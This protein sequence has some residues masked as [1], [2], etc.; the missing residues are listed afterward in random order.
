MGFLIPLCIPLLLL[1][2]DVGSDTFTEIPQ[3]T[4]TELLT[5]TTEAIS[6]P[7]TDPCYNYSILDEPWRATNSPNYWWGL[8][9]DQYI[10][11]NGWYRLLHQ[12][13]SVRMPDSCVSEN[14]CGT[15]APLWLNGPHPRLEDGVVSRQVCGSWNG[16]C[17]YFNSFPIQVKA[18]P[19]NYYVYEFVSPNGCSLAYCADV[20]N[21][22]TTEI[23]QTTTTETLPTTTE[24]ISNPSTD[25]CDNYSILDEPW[26]ATN[27]PNYWWGV[28]CDQYTSWNGWYRLLHQGNSVRMPDS[29]VSENMCG[30]H[31]PLW[32]NGPHPRL[33]DGV[34]SRQVCGSW[35]GACCFFNSSPI[36]V[37]ACPGDYYVYEFVRPSSCSLAYCADV[38]NE[39]TTEIPQTTTTETLPTTTEAISN[40]STDPCDNYSI[41]DEPWRATNS[42]NYWWGVHCD[43]YTSWN[44]WYRLLHQGNSVRMP[45]SCVSENMC[46]THAP[47]WLNGPHPRL[48]DGVVSRQVCGS[49]NG[50]CCFFNSSPI[51]VK[52]CP[53]DYYVYEFVRPSSCS[54]AYCAD[55]GNETTTEI[56]QTT[57]TET[58]PT[59][60]EAI[61]NPSTDPCDNYSILDEPWRATNSPNYWWGVHCDQYTSWNGWYRL[62]H[63]GNSVRMPDS[64]VSENMCGT[65]APLWL[66]GPHPRLEDGVVS[67]QVCGSWNGACCFFNSSPIQVK[68]CPGDYYV[69]EFVRPSSCSLAYCADVGNET[70]TEIPQTTTTETLP[71]TTDVGSI[72]P[73]EITTTTQPPTTTTETPTTTAPLNTSTG[74]FYPFGVG[75]IEN[76]RIDDGGSPAI[77]LLQHFIFFGTTYAQ[78]YVNNNGHLTF[79]Q[80]WYSYVP[81]QFP[82]NAGRDIIAPYWTDIDNYYNGIIS[83]QQYTSGSVLTQATQDINQ[84]FPQL[85]FNATWVFVA[86]WNRVG[87]CCSNSGEETSF[88]V[89]L[90]SD[91]RLSFVLMNY[92]HIAPTSRA[93]QAGY[94]TS[95][96]SYYFSIPGS[97]QRNYNNDFTYTSNVNVTGRWAFRVDHGSQTCQF[98]GNTVPQG[99]SFWTDS[100]CWE[101]CTCTRRGLQC[102]SQ[103]CTYSQACRPAALEYS[104][105]NVQRQTCT[106]SGD[107][108][109]YTFDN[110]IFHFQGTCTYVLSEACGD[111]LPY[112]RI[113]GKNE[114]RGSTRV[115]W[116]RLVRVFVYDEELELVKDHQYEAKVNGSFASTPFSLRNGSIQVYQSG[117][118]VAISTDFGLVVTYDAYSYVTISVPFD[119]QN[120][121]CGL[122]GNFNH[123]PE[124]DFRT[125]SGEV[126]S[127]DTDFANSWT[128]TGDTDPGCQNTCSGLTCAACTEAQ[129]SLYSNSDY[130][131]ILGD[132]AGPFSSCHSRLS[133]QTFMENCIY[134]LCV[135]GGYQPILCQALNVY[136]AQC[137]QQGVQL[138][139]WR[140]QGFCEISC[141]RNSH[142]ESSG[143]S[144]PATCS[145]PTAPVNCPLPNQESCICD[146][147]YV[148][149]AGECVSQANCGCTFEGLYYASGQSVI[150]DGDCGRQCSCNSGVMSCQN[151][152]CGPQEMCAIHNG[153]RGCRPIG[154]STCWVEGPGFYHTY[155]GLMF[156]YPGACEL[157]LSRVM[158]LSPLPNFAVTIQK[159][160]SGPQ[161]FSRVLTF[162]AEGTQVSMKMEEGGTATVDGQEVA[163]PFS[164]GSGR[165]HI[166]HSSVKG[167]IMET[168]FGV[169]VRADWPHLIRIT[170]P[171]TYNGTLGGLC[172]N[173]NEYLE[174]E[175]LSPDGVLLNDSRTF[176][177]SWR[178]GSLS[179]HCEESTDIWQ[180]GYYQDSNQFRMH[181]SILS[182]PSGPFAQCH[183]SLDPSA[184]VEDCISSLQ[185]T[186]GAKEA[187]CEALRGYAVLCQQNGIVLQE[188]RNITDCE[189][190][191]PTNSHYELCGTSCPAACPSLSFPYLCTQHCQEGCQCDDGLLLSGDHCVPPIGCGCLQEGRYRQ[192]GERFWYGEQCQSLCICDGTTGFVRCNPSSCSEQETCRIVGGE[193]GCHPQPR[194][195]CSASGDPH[196]TSFDGRNFDFQ[197][198]CRYILSTVC[199]DNQ[200]LPFFQVVAKNEA[201]NG[202]PVSIT[203]EVSVNVSGH[204]VLVS[205]NKRGIA[206]ID[207]ETKN[208]PVLLDSGS[209]SVYSSGQNTFITTDFGLSVSYD[210]S[211]VVR[212]TVPANYSGATCGL[213]GNFNG[214][215]NDDFRIR[216]GELVSSAS[217]FGADWKVGNDTSCDDE[218]GDSCARCQNPVSARSQCEILRDRQGPVSF[219]HSYVDPEA[220]FNDCAFDLCLSEYQ[221]DVLCRSI[222]TYVSAC[223]SANAP[224]LPW[225][226]NTTCRMDCPMNSHYELCG[227]D[228]EH[229]CASSIDSVCE[230]ACSEG[231][232]C[233]EGFVRSGGFCIPVEQCGC[234]Y[235]GFYFNIGEKF[236]NQECSQHCECFAPNDLRCSSISCSPTQEC[237]VKNGQRGCYS[238]MSSCMVWGDP[239]YLTFDGAVTT[240]QGTCSYEISKTCGNLLDNGLEFLVV[241]TNMHRENK[242][243]SFASVVDIWLS[244]GGQRSQITIGQNK[245]VKVDGTDIDSSAFQIGQLA[246]LHQENDFVVVNASSE[247]MV[248]F[249]GRFTLLVRLDESFH[250]SVCGMCGNN[251]GDAADDK[252]MPSGALA[253]SDDEFGNSWRSEISTQGC[254]A[255]DQR[256][257]V[258]D[259]PFTQEYSEVCSIITNTSGPFQHCHFHVN[260]MVYFRSCVYDLCVYSSANGM[261]CSALEAYEVACT[262]MGLEISEWRSDLGCS[263]TDPCAELE[264]TADEWCGEKDNIYGCFC[265]ENHPRPKKESY[266][267]KEECESSSGTMSLSRCQLF[268]AGFSADILHLSDPNCTGTIQNGRL[269]F[270]FDNDAN[271]CGTNLVANGTHFIYENTIQGGADSARGSIHRKKYLELQ[272]SCIYQISQTLSMDTELTPLQSV[273]RKRLPGQGMYQVRIVPYQDAA[274]SQ[275]YNGSV[276]I[277]VDERIY[278]GVFVQGVDSRQIATV[279]D[280]CWA[281]PENDQNHAV[282][283]DLITNRCPNPEDT[284]V[285][286][287]Q[288]GVSTTGRFSFRMFAFNGDYQKVFL[289]C[290][291]HLCILEGNNCAARCFPGFHHRVG[292]SV[293]IHDMASI[294]VGPFIWTV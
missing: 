214:Q 38:G 111:G 123:H 99:T 151:Y 87:Y 56:P 39:T 245:R 117:F 291:I 52:A 6:N 293:D 262:T 26:R 138:G 220:Y 90:I 21:E 290:S 132:P 247:L 231:C 63:Q 254:G 256:Y 286:V 198:T 188:W 270:S 218:C 37:K 194:A 28:H 240:F 136:S 105:Q 174:D 62:L 271:I 224:V 285:E 25:P 202:L 121:T 122:C 108:H 234:L 229:T 162:E 163:L 222:Q 191:C 144:C 167:I 193:Y 242:D 13:N 83:Y 104:C 276:K 199:S 251:N 166:Y 19:G 47:L 211:W 114:H 186:E 137:Q 277:V 221:H 189:F 227:T 201:W 101:R 142:F 103:P 230:H 288:N 74:P 1:I 81:Y 29:C 68:A 134:D 223:Q 236:W 55:V 53:G 127:S 34:V 31:A 51:Q 67:R 58:L 173:F 147:G 116:T 267:S 16:A 113:E 77:S 7:S 213:C 109:Y 294:S 284:T 119:Y 196:Y 8:H 158:G 259:C 102:S 184:K 192:G 264:C 249:D 124:D 161:G 112:Y 23:P 237:M 10:S 239:H 200:D 215:T 140:R 275:P 243:V 96:S 171:S 195:T 263:Y 14:M 131:G 93:V 32:L 272:F 48:E 78:L 279:I 75:D 98:N 246:E 110:Q 22:T 183:S 179:A 43:Q 69:Y 15:H 60:T 278:V 175:F 190:P 107:P 160:P 133:P 155:D 209:V 204:L 157:T 255:I 125:P 120:A 178:D 287:L 130:C 126:L 5:T 217:Q 97:F 225:R 76:G 106:I 143:T 185:Q 232:F 71:T 197:G 226:Q 11:W 238:T 92:G 212:V 283:W 36:Q 89:V 156:S 182:S 154:Y 65:H 84:Y 177:D 146:A 115:S 135:G 85:H 86:T 145:N 257:D 210:G 27:S 54:L 150:L 172:G 45:D 169:T 280:S 244:K 208:L 216:S 180:K 50:A 82:A 46:G 128:A 206:V 18:C 88:Q 80:S 268:E 260:P 129:R 17:C 57:T 79:D 281:T 248:Y 241:A 289:H 253:P 219:C 148:L 168:T 33:E 42:P 40:P 292:R 49:W 152:Q 66:N 24:A 187:L 20:G 61:S 73:S 64:C 91:G 203:V 207:S 59:T 12:G 165:I 149:S 205:R 2:S 35:N 233:N 266:D 118:S 164:V 70:T 44:G 100:S 141:P 235:N 261:L 274:L 252:A 273:V 258:N 72:T 3:T 250:G 159:Q 228:C 9:C 176:G 269:V 265:N 282:R 30:T 170:V 4:T 139:L 41:L 94:D 153:V 181:C 95:D